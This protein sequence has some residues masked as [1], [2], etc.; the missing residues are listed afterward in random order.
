MKR[1]VTI[2]TLLLVAS[3]ALA[4]CATGTEEAGTATQSAIMATA[5]A[6]ATEAAAAQAA[7]QATADAVTAEAAQALADAQA[8]A[9]AA[10]TTAAEMPTDVPTVVPP[11][12]EPTE[13]PTEEPTEVPT[14][15]PT[16][17]PTEVPPTDVPTEVPPTDVPTVDPA[18]AQ[19][20]TEARQARATQRA[21]AAAAATEAAQ[22]T[23]EPTAEPTEEPTAEPTAV[24][25]E[26]PTAEPTEAPT[27]EAS[28]GVP[29]TVCLVTDLGRV[30]DGT[31]NTYAYEGMLRAEADFTLTTRYIETQSQ[32]D[33]E[34]NINTCLDEGFD[35]VVTVGFLITG[36]TAAAAE[37]NP[38][39]YFIGVDQFHETALPNLVGIQ[40][41]EDQAGYLAG[42]MAALMT[43]TNKV[44]GVYGIDI[45]PVRKFRNG[46]EQGAK[47]VN[48]DIELFG[49]Y[50][51]DFLAPQLGAEAADA[52][53]SE[54]GVDVVFGAG[55]PTGSGG[56]VQAAGLGAWVIG[57]DQDEYIT[58]F[59]NGEAPNADKIITSAMKRV[60]QGVYDM[61][62]VLVGGGSF[63][64][65][66]LYLMDA[67]VNGVGFAPAHD[68][69]VPE[70][71]TAQVQAVLDG[72]TSGEIETGVDPV[73]GDL[74]N[75]A[76]VEEATE[77]T[78][79]EEPTAAPTEE[80]TAEPT[81]EAAAEPTAA[82]APGETASTVCLVTDIGRINDGTFNTYAYDGM[83]RAEADLGLSTRFIETQAQADYEANINTCLDE[84][85][86]IIVTVGFLITGATATA[87]ETHPD[88]YFIGVDQF[89]DTALPNL[90]GIQFREDQ[91]GY[92]AGAMAALM[93]ESGKVGGVYGID[94]PPV[95]KFRNGFEQGAKSINPDIELFGVYI[96]D[97][98]APQLGAEAADAMVSE[99]GVDVIFGAGGPTGSGA[100]VQAAA[101]GAWVIG[102]DQD[103]YI[104]TFGDGEAPNAD[105]IISSAMK[106]VDQGVYDM[107]TAVVNGTGFA[108]NSLY[109]M[110]ASINGVGFAP[111]H[112]APVPEDVTAQVQA[113]L[114]GMAAGEIET[115]VDPVTGD[116]LEATE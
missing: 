33:Y 68:A 15:V 72:L 3:F 102:V 40:F 60:D 111:A 43:E 69:P 4:A 24:P 61:I 18:I 9:D 53:V 12:E 6:Q 116:L 90:V 27:E 7:L 49:V 85:F 81:E 79:A 112:D 11:T 30:N 29:S 78:P 59:G 73:T 92:L 56:I 46:F 106:R 91:A 31:F 50:I 48:P 42:V 97:F 66:S 93:T 88:V 54:E 38:S 80:P 16:D 14:E 28:T 109:L 22:P 83:L 23:E 36:A 86:D 55:G 108:E 105:K 76:P 39:V 1:F 17:V 101:L 77:E 10:A 63:P 71:V 94:I 51:P 8:T 45:P 21:E 65:G 26:E 98:L 95:R 84:G 34:A 115:G 114:D 2:V 13:V 57:V 35:I 104:T 107:I 74:L 25:T 52:M 99:E 89:Y 62:G 19:A 64:E 32:A 20:T 67:A 100:I 41:R 96:P 87:A 44:G 75:A 113:I 58:T 47:S 5:D 110:D 70:E 103:E 37:A 82:P